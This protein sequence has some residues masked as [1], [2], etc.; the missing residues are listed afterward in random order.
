MTSRLGAFKLTLVT[1]EEKIVGKI[2]EGLG[3][4]KLI[5]AGKLPTKSAKAF[6]N[7]H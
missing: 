7:E 6:L 2:S 1:A 4:V 3:E 5:E